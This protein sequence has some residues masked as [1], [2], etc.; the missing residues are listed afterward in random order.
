MDKT[1]VTV[2][3]IIK[4]ENVTWKKD[5]PVEVVS[6]RNEGPATSQGA[7]GSRSGLTTGYAHPSSTS[8]IQIIL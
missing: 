1:Q 8:Y 3:L 2:M 5:E 6:G 7:R 4:P